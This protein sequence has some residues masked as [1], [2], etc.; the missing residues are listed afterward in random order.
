MGNEREEDWETEDVPPARL[1]TISTR[2]VDPKRPRAGR[3]TTLQPGAMVGR[4]QILATLGAGGMGVVYKALDPDLDRAVALKLVSMRDADAEASAGTRARLLREAMA[5]AQLAH[6]NVVAIHHV[7][8]IQDEVFIAME[9][10]EGATLR[11]WLAAAPRS[12]REILEVFLAAGAGLAAAHEVGIVHRDFKPDN[13]IIGNDGRVRVLDFGL[14][15]SREPVDVPP[16]ASAETRDLDEP[17]DFA[18]ELAERD[19]DALGS[20]VNVA[21]RLTRVGTVTG[22]PA[23]MSPEQHLAGE[24]D[25]RS[26]QFSFCVALHEALY[27]RR[28]FVAENR[29]LLRLAVLSGQIA[30]PPKRAGVTARVRRAVWQGLSRRPDD[31]HASMSV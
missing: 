10:V 29:E 3:R 4:Y 23:Y 8:S 17:R 11:S 24:V 1:D 28:P 25:A 19:S 31:R 20:Q 7:G 6:P 15:R 14:A 30:T 21:S 13:V 18:A 16:H 12:P 26:D 5:L 9:F 2:A 22:T 27:G